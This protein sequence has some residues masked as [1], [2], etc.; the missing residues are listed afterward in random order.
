M[1]RSD[2]IQSDDTEHPL[3]TIPYSSEGATERMTPSELESFDRLEGVVVS[4]GIVGAFVDGDF[5]V[6]EL[7]A[8]AAAAA[9]DLAGANHVRLAGKDVD[10][11]RFFLGGSGD[12]KG[13]D[14]ACRESGWLGFHHREK[15][16]RGYS[17][18]V[19]FR[20]CHACS[21]RQ[22][23]SRRDSSTESRRPC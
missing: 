10:F 3:A 23:A 8:P 2:G 7:G 18:L 5:G 22:N 14:Q 21:D 20:G 1:N 12:A 13:C 11:D 16:W 6:E 15:C 17:S 9:V 4:F 19:V